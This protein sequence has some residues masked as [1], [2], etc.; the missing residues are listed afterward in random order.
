[1]RRKRLDYWRDVETYQRYAFDSKEGKKRIEEMEKYYQEFKDFLGKRVLDVA[2]GAGLFSFWLEQKGY[3]VVG[4]DINKEMIRLALKTKKKYNF[5]SQ[6]LLSDA[7]SVKLNDIFDSAIIFGNT[8][9]SLSPK[10]FVNIIKN[11]KNHLKENGYVII[12][13]RSLVEK[14]VNKEWKDV[15]FDSENIISFNLKYDDSQAKITKIYVDLNGEKLPTK[16]P[17]YV[18]SSGFLEAIMEAL[19]FV[20]IK[21]IETKVSMC[22]IMDIYQKKI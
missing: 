15:Y 17:F 4:V 12:N 16:E 6:F 5:K 18:W 8:L 20:L 9:F 14:L 21:R 1:M 10:T 11:I 2:C 19:G 3:E 7:T 13:Y 22:E